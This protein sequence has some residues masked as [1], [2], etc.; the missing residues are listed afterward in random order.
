MGQAEPAAAVLRQAKQMAEQAAD[1]SQL[2]V[3]ADALLNIHA[4]AGRFDLAEPEVELLRRCAREH[5]DKPDG[6]P[7]VRL[8]VHGALGRFFDTAGDTATARSEYEAAIALAEAEGQHHMAA[9]CRVNLAGLLGESG[10]LAGALAML[11]RA[12]ESLEISGI[13]RP[14]A[15]CVGNIGWVEVQLDRPDEAEASLRHAA[16]LCRQIGARFDLATVLG[17]LGNALADQ[18]RYDEAE[19]LLTEALALCREAGQRRH[20]GIVL[21]DLALVRTRSGNPQQGAEL[22]RQAIAIN[23]GFNNLRSVV[24]ARQ[25]LANALALMGAAEESERE[26]R[27]GLETARVINQPRWVC[28]LAWSLAMLLK[29]TGRQAEFHAALDECVAAANRVGMTEYV[30]KAA[31]LRG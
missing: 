7:S 8:R 15:I 5:P 6:K 31:A 19:A 1:I 22:A 29:D 23:T 17:N 12:R 13:L 21:G 9:V 25:A 28:L 14:L 2:V 3:A 24:V 18:T 30:N 11:R 26:L 16:N 20:E 27:A 10:D 4:T